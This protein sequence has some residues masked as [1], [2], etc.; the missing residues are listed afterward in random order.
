MVKGKEINLDVRKKIVD[1]DKAEQGYRVISRKF[2]VSRTA[3][4][5]IIDDVNLS[6]FSSITC[7]SIQDTEIN[8]VGGTTID[9]SSESGC[10]QDTVITALH[11]DNNSGSLIKF[12]CHQ[13]NG[14][15][16]DTSNC[17]TNTMVMK[18][19]VGCSYTNRY[20]MTAI[21]VPNGSGGTFDYLCC[22]IYGAS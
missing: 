2:I 19:K 13:I 11:S 7:N 8:L 21:W 3:V 22:K 14:F 18:T 12:V 20:V 4:R 9:V 15:K 6:T 5:S 10:P 1:A 17:N 16:V